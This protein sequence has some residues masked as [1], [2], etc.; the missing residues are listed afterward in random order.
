MKKYSKVALRRFNKKTVAGMYGIT[1]K[2]LNAWLDDDKL[3]EELGP[4]EGRVFTP[5][6]LHIIEKYIGKFPNYES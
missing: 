5:S 1:L 4:Y 2:V 3:L 6:Q